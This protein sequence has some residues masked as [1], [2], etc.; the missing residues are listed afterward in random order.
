M[1]R[2]LTPT[3]RRW[4]YGVTTA[5]LGVCLVYGLVDGNQVAAWAGLAAAVT[6]MA[7]AFVDETATPRHAADDD[8]T[9]P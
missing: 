6:G 7:G 8:A 1:T 4:A 2:Y 5:A 9:R 3:V